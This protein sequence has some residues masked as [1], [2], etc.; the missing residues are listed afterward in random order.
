MNDLLEILLKLVAAILIIALFFSLGSKVWLRGFWVNIKL[1]TWFLFTIIIVAIVMVFTIDLVGQNH[2][3]MYFGM[4]FGVFG[5]SF[6]VSA[7][8]FEEAHRLSSTELC[9]KITDALTTSQQRKKRIQGV[10]IFI[11]LIGLML[12]ILDPFLNLTDPRIVLEKLVLITLYTGGF[13][14][15]TFCFYSIARIRIIYPRIGGMVQ[16]D[17]I[18]VFP[19]SPELLFGWK[20]V[21]NWQEFKKYL[22]QLLEVRIHVLLKS[23]LPERRFPRFIWLGMLLF[24]LT[25]QLFIGTKSLSIISW[26][27]M[28]PHKP[29][30]IIVWALAFMTGYVEVKTR[31]HYLSRLQER[32]NEVDP[33]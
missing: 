28:Q 15:I 10:G 16:E 26:S 3:G 31:R 12:A 33:T 18:A 25:L 2:P 5:I 23:L 7:S 4:A 21:E 30:L 32:V 6:V 14:I 29:Y 9:L 22:P 1:V 17:L 8:L 19:P 13:A 11:I 20:R 27:F 24:F